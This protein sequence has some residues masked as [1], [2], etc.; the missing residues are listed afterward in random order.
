MVED[1][2]SR[3]GSVGVLVRPA[4]GVDFFPLDSD[5][6]V[7]ASVVGTDPQPAIFRLLD[8]VPKAFHAPWIILLSISDSVAKRR[9]GVIHAV[10]RLRTASSFKAV[11][12]AGKN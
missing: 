6:S 1:Q 11:L 7:T 8:L 4:V 2:S 10:H 3:D 9:E 5:F 12:R